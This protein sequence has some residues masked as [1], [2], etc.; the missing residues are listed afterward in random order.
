M[1]LC[2]LTGLLIGLLIGGRFKV[3]ATVPVQI[4]GLSAAATP[5][6]FGSA[7]FAHQI[8]IGITF[9]A[10]VQAGYMLRLLAGLAYPAPVAC[11]KAEA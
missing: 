1:I 7:T 4:L 8:A 5:A 6:I 9:C 3:F 10:A 11:R 2:G